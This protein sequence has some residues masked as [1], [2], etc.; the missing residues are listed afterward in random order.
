MKQEQID[1][2]NTLAG[3]L[4]TE[5]TED[6]KVELA[7]LKAI[8]EADD[9]AKKTVAEFWK[10]QSKTVF[11]NRPEIKVL[12]E[13]LDNPAIRFMTLVKGLKTRNQELI[14]KTAD[15]QDVATSA[16][17]GITVPGI[18]QARILELVPT[19]GQARSYMN[20][21]PMGG[22]VITI[23]KELTNPTAYWVDENNTITDSKLTLESITLTPKKLAAIV[24]ITNE[25]LA[26]SNVNFSAYVLSKIAQAFGT[27]E[28]VQFF[29]GSGSPMSGVFRNTHTF[30]K[31][32]RT[33][34]QN[35]NSLTYL[36]FLNA[37]SG[38]DQN[39]VAG[40]SWF[41]HRTV[42][43]TVAGMKDDNNRPLLEPAFGSTP[44]SLFGIPIRLIEN[45]PS[46]SGADN[47]DQP[48]I[49]LG[50]L[51]NSFIGDTLGM[52][53]TIV[54]T[55]TVDSTSL[56]ENDLTGIRV[57]KRTSFNAGLV[58]KYAVISTAV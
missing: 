32:E 20:S 23:P 34:T 36:N 13:P 31:E 35:L 46:Y 8:K 43:P 12:S 11:A 29:N 49:L 52:T 38:V 26:D 57:I 17:G 50:N 33:S 21:F 24:T 55:G 7:D 4:V 44:A 22:N 54:N 40:A 41:F 30:G 9:I 15:P 25:L 19:F 37:L 51:Q 39:Y 2:L 47:D 27:E 53:V 42:L 16:D 28:D 1:R 58:A 48:Y 10:E 18:T 14:Q 45:A 5:L 56:F 6:E 3:K